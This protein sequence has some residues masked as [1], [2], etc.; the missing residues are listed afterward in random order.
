MIEYPKDSRHCWSP[1]VILAHISDK[2][3]THV[4]FYD[5]IDQYLSNHT[6]AIEI[7]ED[8]FSLYSTKR[9]Q[10]EQNLR[11]Q[12]IV[13]LNNHTKTYLLGTIIDRIESGHKYII[14][15]CNEQQDTQTEDHLFGT[16][17]R[18]NLCQINDRVLALDDD[19][20]IYLPATIIDQSKDGKTLTVRFADYTRHD[21]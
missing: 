4:R 18:R 8:K 21:K 9:I 19:Q 2:S 14:R 20:Y 11:D 1:A 16:L 17:M 7:S 6:D 3:E 12:A 13:G 5:G 10:F 15:W